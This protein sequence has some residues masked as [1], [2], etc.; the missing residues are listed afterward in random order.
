MH[1]KA[2]EINNLNII[3]MPYHSMRIRNFLS[4]KERKLK[5]IH[6]V[7]DLTF[8]VEEGEI[9]GIIGRNG[10]GKTTLLRAVAGIFSPDSGKIEL[11]GNKVSLM[12][13]GV[14]FDPELTG[15]DNIILSGMMLG[16]QRGYI[17]DRLE[18]IIDFSELGDFADYPVRTYSSGMYARL[19]FSITSLLEAD[20]MLID[21]V[22]SV[23]DASFKI[24]SEKKL[25]ELMED[26]RH[27]VLMVSHDEYSLKSLCNRLILLDEGQIKMEGDPEMVL[28]EYHS[29]LQEEK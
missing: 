26:R 24:K 22:L 27:T 3:Y 6:A 13:L 19:A 7:K 21:E 1:T 23:G 25:K 2:L 12:A 5:P 28:K 4:D 16:F 8:S 10:S 17:R 29:Y 15:K 18:E 14:G 11:F 20:I 9:L